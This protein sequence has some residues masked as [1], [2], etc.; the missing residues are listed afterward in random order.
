VPSTFQ[1][2]EI[3]ALRYITTAGQVD[4]CWPC[5][6]VADR[7]DLLALFIAAGSIVVADPKRTAAEK[8]A[9][10]PPPAPLGRMV[11]RRDT[12]RLLLP[13]QQ[14]SVWL[15][16]ERAGA[17]RR[18]TGYFVNLEE[19]FRRTRIGIDTQDHTLDVVVNPELRWRWRDEEDFDSHVTHGFFTPQLAAAV[20]A[21]G[22]RVVAAIVDR[23]HPCL[24]G[25]S[26]W[27]PDPAWEIPSLPEGWDTTPSDRWERWRW[28]YGTD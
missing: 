1:P 9:A 5:R 24:G 6:V 18:F 2:G 12:L 7:P 21:E 27:V 17:E 28:A 3:I 23:T 15:N 19:P 10:A 16:W 13:G 25:W 8:R 11:W 4:F 26:D 22:E 20:R 14:H